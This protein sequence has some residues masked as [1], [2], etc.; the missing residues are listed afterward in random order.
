[1][2]IQAHAWNKSKAI[3]RLL[4]WRKF[5]ASKSQDT[6]RLWAVSTLLG[7]RTVNDPLLIPQEHLPYYHLGLLQA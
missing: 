6:F 7:K 4:V 1:M 5:L 3:W 2:P